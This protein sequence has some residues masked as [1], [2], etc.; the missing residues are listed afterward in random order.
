M[1]C[2]AQCKTSRQKHAEKVRNVKTCATNATAVE[3]IAH[4]QKQCLS[5]FLCRMKN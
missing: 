5:I 1:Q 4:G 3:A 2:N